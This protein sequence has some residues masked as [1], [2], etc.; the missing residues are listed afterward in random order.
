[1][2]DDTFDEILDDLYVEYYDVFER[3]KAGDKDTIEIQNTPETS[4]KNPS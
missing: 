4:P 1:M 3:L 2:D